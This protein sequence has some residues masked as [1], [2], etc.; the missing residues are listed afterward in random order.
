MQ[1]DI[2]VQW[3]ANLSIDLLDMPLE[4]FCLTFSKWGAQYGPITWITVPGR[5]IVVLNTYDAI[6]EL[7]DRRG[8]NHI[9]RARMVMSAELIGETRLSRFPEALHLRSVDL[10]LVFTT[11]IKKADS[12]WKKHRKFFHQALSLETVKREYSNLFLAKAHQ[13]LETIL[14]QPL[15]FLPSLKRCVGQDIVMFLACRWII[16]RKQRLGG[17]HR[18]AYLRSTQP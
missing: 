16:K 17:D 10:G 9:D 12:D 2:F 8:S 13:Y 6:E 15:D 18:G 11:P 4:R 3:G 7:L 14:H 5:N 1:Q